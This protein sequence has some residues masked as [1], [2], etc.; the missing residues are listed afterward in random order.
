MATPRAITIRAS[1]RRRASRISDVHRCEPY[2]Y[3]QTI[4]GRDAPTHGEAKSSRLTGTASWN[5]YAITQWI[6]GIRPEYEGLRVA[7][8]IPLRWPGFEA[9]RKFRGVTYRIVVKRAGPGNAVT[10]TVDGRPVA[11][12]IVPP[13]AEGQAEVAVEARIG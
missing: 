8:V 10:L 13:P 11:G 5:Y 7:P 9:T 3:A 4:A 6:L 1:I 12:N 2:A